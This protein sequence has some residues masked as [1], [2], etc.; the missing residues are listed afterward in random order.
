MS[1]AVDNESAAA[2]PLRL[3]MRRD[4]QF[5]RQQ[6]GVDR[7]W[8]VKD[9]VA[10][11]YFH[12][13][14]EEYAILQALDGHTSLEQLLN[15]CNETFAPNRLSIE[16]IHGFLATLYRNGLVLADAPGQDA[17]LLE[18]RG[19]KRRRQRFESLLSVLAIRFRGVNPR[20]L[21][22]WLYPACGWLFSPLTAIVVLGLALAAAALVVV[23]FATV[24]ARLPEF[25]AI[26]SAS[27]LPWLALTLAVVKV[28]HELGHALAC[29]H[30]GGDCHEMGVML[31]VFTPCLYCNVSD[32]W[33]MPSKWQRIAIA[34]AGMYVEL[35][36]ASVCTFLWWFSQE[37]LFNSLC[38]NTVLIC[39]LGTLLLNGNPLLRYDGYFIFSDLVG[40]P[41]LKSQ[42]AAAVRRLLARWCLGLELPPE[43]LAPSG[44]QGLLVLYAV[45]AAA[46]RVF[47][48]VLVLWV[49]HEILRP[50][51]LEVLV[52][53]VA[54]VTI[55][56]MAWPAVETTARW[57]AIRRGGGAWRWRAWR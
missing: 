56:G 2:R 52:G 1:V 33:M 38:L 27:N 9:P 5:R 28:L 36:L 39:S 22:D 12:L 7:Y 8:A 18:R 32:S 29:R 15:R 41:N 42:S 3:R 13:R 54:A 34:A 23:Q 50:L 40:V 57:R 26:V 25:D 47:V 49:L 31:L 35:I 16:Q 55:V 4:L 43:R 45:A 10:L 20:G 14:E 17:P 37:G 48:I 21:L 44:R 11:K 6:F 30:Y 51:H 19:E 53:V 46:Y 24:E